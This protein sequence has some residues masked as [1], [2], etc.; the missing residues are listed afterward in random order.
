[1]ELSTLDLFWLQMTDT[2]SHGPGRQKF[3]EPTGR[4]Q[5]CPSGSLE[6]E[7]LSCREWLL[8]HPGWCDQPK[9]SYLYPQRPKTL[10]ANS[11]KGSH[12]LL[13]GS[14]HIYLWTTRLWPRKR[15]QAIGLAQVT[16]WP[17]K[18]P[19][20]PMGWDLKK[21]G[22]SVLFWGERVCPGQGRKL[23]SWAFWVTNIRQ[24]EII[25]SLEYDFL[26]IKKHQII[27]ISEWKHHLFQTII[28]CILYAEWRGVSIWSSNTCRN[29]EDLLLIMNM[30]TFHA[31]KSPCFLATSD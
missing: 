7:S 10:V 8:Q 13:L 16:Y 2:C 4:A 9:G 21:N 25:S 3:H 31:S 28:P 24:A 19:L 5:G 20:W 30:S 12:W 6:L 29:R 26:P 17:L 14:V 15:G 11:G 18:Q 1:M 23:F 27:F 22:D